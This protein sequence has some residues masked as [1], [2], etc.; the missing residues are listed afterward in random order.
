MHGGAPQSGRADCLPA[1]ALVES[2]ASASSS[3]A[4]NRHEQPTKP[5]RTKISLVSGRVCDESTLLVL[6]PEAFSRW[7]PESR[8]AS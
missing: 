1:G 6:I 2:V 5:G 8:S 3:D 4:S 7:K